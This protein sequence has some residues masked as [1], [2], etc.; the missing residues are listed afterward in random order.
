MRRKTEGKDAMVERRFDA[1]ERPFGSVAEIAV[2]VV[3][4]PSHGY[5]PV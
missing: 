2:A 5:P 3:I 1:G 4:Y